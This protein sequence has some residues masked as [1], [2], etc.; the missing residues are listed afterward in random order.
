MTTQPERS[1]TSNPGRIY[2]ILG[3]VFGVIALLFIPILFGP[4]GII[5]GFVGH[6]KGD[7][8]LG[9]YVGIG[10][11]VTTIVGMV[12]GALVWGAMN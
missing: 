6:A 5:L 3:A 9:M 10:S 12:L 4:A 2:T 8:P 7:K 1:T 11:I